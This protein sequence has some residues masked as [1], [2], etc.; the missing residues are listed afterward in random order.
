METLV[1]DRMVLFMPDEGG[2]FVPLRVAGFAMS[3]PEL[4]RRSGL[5]GRLDAGHVV[6][7]DDPLS[8]RR[9]SDDE[10]EYWRDWGLYLLRALRREGRHHRR[11]GARAA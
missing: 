11:A 9:F 6:A 4:A 2:D 5:G 3:P 1:V 10:L 7:L 8:T